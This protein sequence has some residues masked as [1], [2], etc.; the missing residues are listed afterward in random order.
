MAVHAVASV[1]FVARRS[2]L[3]RRLDDLL[4]EVSAG[5]SDHLERAVLAAKLSEC[6]DRLARVEVMSA[7][8]LDG[9]TWAEVGRAFGVSTQTAHER[10]RAGPDGLHSR[11]FKRQS[12]SEGGSGSAAIVGAGSSSRRRNALRKASDA[13]S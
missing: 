13:R 9:A 11:Y 10:F 1:T 2:N 3:Q 6:A 12:N 4:D 7:R 5:T 8:E